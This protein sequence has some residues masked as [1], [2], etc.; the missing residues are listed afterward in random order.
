MAITVNIWIEMAKQTV[1]TQVR[2]R[3]L[4]KEQSN[5][6]LHCLSV[7]LHLPNTLLHYKTELYYYR[8]RFS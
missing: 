4:L 5:Q 1:Q 3:L 7:Y 6:G 2:L 8:I